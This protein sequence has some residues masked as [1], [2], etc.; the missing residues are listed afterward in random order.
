MGVRTEV[1]L[2]RIQAA[3]HVGSQRAALPTLGLAAANEHRAVV[4]VEPGNRRVRTLMLKDW[5]AE[6]TGSRVEK[7]D[8]L[9]L[10]SGRARSDVDLSRTGAC[11]ER[12]EI[13]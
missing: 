2:E 3:L 7:I 10:L 5:C 12:F 4:G 1:R 8:S 11:A 6:L 13:A 9:K